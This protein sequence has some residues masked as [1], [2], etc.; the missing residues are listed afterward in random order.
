MIAGRAEIN[1]SIA[2][3]MMAILTVATLAL[4]VAMRTSLVVSRREAGLLLF[5]YAAFIVWVSLESFGVIDTVRGL[6]PQ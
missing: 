5:L 3:P 4:F 6:P 1:F 2:T